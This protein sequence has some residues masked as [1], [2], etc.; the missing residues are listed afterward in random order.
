[1]PVATRLASL[2][3]DFIGTLDPQPEDENP[4]FYL[5]MDRIERHSAVS[6]HALN[7]EL[8]AIAERFGVESYDGMAVGDVDGP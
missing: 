4:V 8:Y 3:F 6:L 5:R 2:G 7:K 1:M